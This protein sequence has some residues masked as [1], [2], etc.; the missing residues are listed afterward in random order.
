MSRAQRLDQ[1]LAAIALTVLD[2]QVSKDLRTRM[3]QLPSR[4]RGSGLA[5]TYAFV[6]S[7]SDPDPNKELGY[8]YH[9]LA[10]AIADHVS[11]RGL[12]GAAGT[13]ITSQG[14]PAALAHATPS[15]YAR[16]SAE[17]DALAGWL[18]RLADALHQPSPPVGRGSG[19]EA[20]EEDRDGER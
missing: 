5:A 4:L 1:E 7:K 6:L 8:A 14:L 3:R 11:R 15:Q 16:T 9:R 18:S 17:I 13:V 19:Q 20:G 2:N 10:A 12:L